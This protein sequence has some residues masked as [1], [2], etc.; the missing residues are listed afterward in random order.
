MSAA[1][2]PS[3]DIGSILDDGPWTTAQILAS[4]IAALAIILDGFDGQLIGFAIPSLIQEW[5][6]SRGDFAP[7]VAAGLVGMAVGSLIAG[8][9]GDRFG[10]RVALFVSVFLFG[11]AT[12]VIG[13][14]PNLFAIGALRFIAGLGIGGTLP[15]AT[16][17]A[18]EFTPQRRRALVVTATIVSFPLGGVLAGLFAASVMPAYG[19]RGL[20][21]IGGLVPVAFA[22]LLLVVL[23]ES[24]RYLAHHEE[25]RPELL[26]LLARFGRTYPVDAVF[27]DPAE[28]AMSLGTD[29]PGGIGSLFEGTRARD[30][31]GLWLAFFACLFAI[32]S[33]F[34]WLPTMLVADGVPQSVAGGALTAYN[35]GGVF[36]AL[37]CAQFITR[38]GSRWPMIVCAA[39][40]AATV[41]LLRLVPTSDT[42]LIV[43]AFGLH[44][45]FVNAVNCTLYA[46]SAFLYPTEIRATGTATALGIGRLGAILSA[47]VGA[48]LITVGGASAYLNALGLAM[49]VVTIA[50]AT[51]R[52]HIAPVTRR[53]AVQ[54][55]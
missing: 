50:L 41:L 37:L 46:V 5:G 29:R 33:V 2:R 30:T 16:T 27:I 48:A 12:S 21:L 19:W 22:F 18:A 11:A 15:S 47:F 34:S 4:V 6:V 42:T 25:R 52:H 32:Y 55:A 36:G 3:Y 54:P 38:F 43:A 1:A 49:I 39:G 26:K 53:V 10:R 45:L 17:L 13:L 20:F 31:V 23:P 24:P 35:L 7:V 40:G 51:L 44:G 9:I 8:Y 28:Q 14:A